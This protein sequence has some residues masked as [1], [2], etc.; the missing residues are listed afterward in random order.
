MTD[1]TIRKITV[2]GFVKAAQ[3]QPVAMVT[4]YDYLWA[5]IMDDAGVDR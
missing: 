2:P 4:A 5:G 3:K 1:N